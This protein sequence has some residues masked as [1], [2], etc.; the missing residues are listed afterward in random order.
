MSVGAKTTWNNANQFW[1]MYQ[2]GVLKTP[3]AL[4]PV[5]YSDMFVMN[6]RDLPDWSE[7]TDSTYAYGV[8][9]HH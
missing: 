6:M 1:D 4:P 5:E 9:S 3:L 7:E 8:S 2:N